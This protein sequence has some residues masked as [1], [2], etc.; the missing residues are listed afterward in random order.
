MIVLMKQS[1]KEIID[2][3]CL[4]NTCYHQS[5]LSLEHDPLERLKKKQI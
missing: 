3:E 4:K 2:V 1:N 5:L